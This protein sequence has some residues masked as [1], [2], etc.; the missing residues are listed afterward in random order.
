MRGLVGR[1]C[2]LIL[3]AGATVAPAVLYA[4]DIP[5]NCGRTMCTGTCEC[6][7]TDS[8]IACSCSSCG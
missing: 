3:L 7:G 8:A 5:C 1:L 2:V 6:W 4:D